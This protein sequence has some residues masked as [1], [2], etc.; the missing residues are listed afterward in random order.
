MPIADRRA[1]AE[2]GRRVPPAGFGCASSGG[3][4]VGGMRDG[5]VLCEAT[6]DVTMTVRRRRPRRRPPHIAAAQHKRTQGSPRVSETGANRS[7]DKLLT[8][9]APSLAQTAFDCWLLLQATARVE[10]PE[11]PLEAALDIRDL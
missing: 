6:T 9:S 7:G 8:P 1:S 10:M 5:S 3:E 11:V 4:A 2:S